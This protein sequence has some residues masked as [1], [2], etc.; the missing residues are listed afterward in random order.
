MSM[1]DRYPSQLEY[2][3]YPQ[4]P[5]M[6]IPEGYSVTSIAARL[7]ADG[8]GMDDDDGLQR[9]EITVEHWDKTVTVL[10]GYRIRQ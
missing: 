5:D 1:S 2:K 7:D 6:D 3:C 9:I 8:D 4:K 10:E